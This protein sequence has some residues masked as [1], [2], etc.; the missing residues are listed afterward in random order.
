MKYSEFKERYRTLNLQSNPDS[1]SVSQESEELLQQ[2][3]KDKYVNEVGTRVQSLHKDRRE[4][5]LEA[6]G[7]IV[8]QIFVLLFN[9]FIPR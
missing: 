9:T 7:E 6:S 8:V 2:A 3:Q 4:G 5:E 1:K